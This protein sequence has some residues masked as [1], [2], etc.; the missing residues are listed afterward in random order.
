MIN[1]TLRT[2]TYPADCDPKIMAMKTVNICVRLYSPFRTS[3]LPYQNA[4][5]IVRNMIV[6]ASPNH[7]FENM[8]VRNAA[9]DGASNDRL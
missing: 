1:A 4:S 5:A 3:V 7:I 6:S 8:A 2:F 9:R